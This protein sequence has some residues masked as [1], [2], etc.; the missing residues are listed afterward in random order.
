VRVTGVRFAVLPLVLAVACG[1]GGGGG[2]GGPAAAGT[3]SRAGVVAAD[4]EIL[5]LGSRIRVSEAGQYSG[6]YVVEDTGRAIKGHELDL[7][8]PNDREAQTFGRRRVQVEVL[9]RGKGN[10]RAATP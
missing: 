3:G 8:L 7:Y 1:Q 4:P 9:E 2:A 6:E 10:R 5:P